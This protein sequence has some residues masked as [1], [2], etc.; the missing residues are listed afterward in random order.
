[1]G[2]L[3]LGGGGCTGMAAFAASSRVTLRVYAVGLWVVW[4]V[5]VRGGVLLMRKDGRGGGLLAGG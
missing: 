5:F 2:M 4:V 3:S 1:M